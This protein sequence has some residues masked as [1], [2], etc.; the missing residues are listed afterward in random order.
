[1]FYVCFTYG[2]INHNVNFFIRIFKE[3]QGI[4]KTKKHGCKVQSLNL[5]ETHKVMHLLHCGIA[6]G[7]IDFHACSC[8]LL[9]DSITSLKQ[10]R[11]SQ[12]IALKWCQH[13]NRRPFWISIVEKNIWILI[14]TVIFNLFPGVVWVLLKSDKNPWYA[15][16]LYVNF[17]TVMD[18]N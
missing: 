14:L 12:W 13:N 8:C 15:V 7:H 9:A 6:R 2:L 17:W 11:N 16:Q 3:I 5:P 18:S 10:P 1:M 4:L